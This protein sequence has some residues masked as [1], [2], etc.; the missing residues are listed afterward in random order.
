MLGKRL[1]APR[2]AE[3]MSKFHWIRM[4]FDRFLFFVF[5]VNL[6]VLYYYGP[7]WHHSA[8]LV[9]HLFMASAT[10]AGLLVELKLFQ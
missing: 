3:D 7:V 10:Q 6:E 9:E 8:S 2:I 1:T 5:F 4:S